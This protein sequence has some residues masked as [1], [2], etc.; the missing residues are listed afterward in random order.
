M[1]E[2]LTLLFFYN[3]RTNKRAHKRQ[4]RFKK[5]DYKC[6]PTLQRKILLSPYRAEKDFALCVE[7]V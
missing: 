5:L 3:K 7:N 1:Y 2:I 6:N 4:E